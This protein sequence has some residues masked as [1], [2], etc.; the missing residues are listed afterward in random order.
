MTLTHAIMNLLY[1]NLGVYEIILIL[2]GILL[3][4]VAL[5]D[6]LRSRFKPVEKLMWV[7]IVLFANLLGVILYLL[8]GFKQ[9]TN[10]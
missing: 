8:I 2:V 6:I 1:L 5:I 9:K 7:F 10:Q 4:L 3:P